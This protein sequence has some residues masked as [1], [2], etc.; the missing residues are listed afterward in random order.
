VSLPVEELVA[1]HQRR[2]LSEPHAQTLALMDLAIAG[3]AEDRVTDSVE[4]ITR[5][6]P[7]RFDDFVTKSFKDATA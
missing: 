1:V 6:T 4:R 7:R 5:H 3:G 2:G